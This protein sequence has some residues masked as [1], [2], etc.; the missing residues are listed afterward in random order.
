MSLE[1]PDCA[2]RLSNSC[3]QRLLI[4]PTAV[5]IVPAWILFRLHDTEESK[6]EHETNGIHGG[7]LVWF[8]RC[9][10][11]VRRGCFEG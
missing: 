8:R 11:Y 3:R 10:L 1:Y 9:Q 6:E 7:E 2:L 5:A 4:H